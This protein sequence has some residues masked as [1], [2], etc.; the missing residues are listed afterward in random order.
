MM[1][2]MVLTALLVAALAANVALFAWAGFAY[3]EWPYSRQINGVLEEDVT[4]GGIY[5][6][7]VSVVRKKSCPIRV[8]RSF[9]DG[10][11]NR[12]QDIMKDFPGKTRL[13]ERHDYSVTYQVPGN[14][15]PGKGRVCVALAPQ[16]NVIQALAKPYHYRSCSTVTILPRQ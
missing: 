15:R 13:G 14:A 12:V 8:H 1:V 3:H 2:R 7:T 11:G 10:A 4:P 6:A 9:W 5:H 16:C